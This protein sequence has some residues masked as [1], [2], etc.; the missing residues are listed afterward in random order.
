L[1]ADGDREMT[2]TNRKMD[3]E[4]GQRPEGIAFLCGINDPKINI[5]F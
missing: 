1:V 3:E 4:D 5:N 2:K